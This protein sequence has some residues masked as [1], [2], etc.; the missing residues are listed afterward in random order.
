MSRINL[1]LLNLGVHLTSV[2][3]MTKSLC[4]MRKPLN[5]ENNVSIANILASSA[6]SDTSVMKWKN[7]SKIVCNFARKDVGW[8]SKN[9]K[10]KIMT[11]SRPLEKW[12]RRMMK[13]SITLES[14]MAFQIKWTPSARKVTPSKST[15]VRYCLNL[16][17]KANQIANSATDKTFTTY[18]SSTF[19][20]NVN[21]LSANT[22]PFWILSLHRS[23]RSMWIIRCTLIVL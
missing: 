1:C 17:K 14:N 13:K 15:M 22:A 16:P 12:F 7:T 9:Q 10:G 3:M 23:E 20:K 11:V 4:H 21:I 19:A 6:K 8:C 5:M 18:H 2:G